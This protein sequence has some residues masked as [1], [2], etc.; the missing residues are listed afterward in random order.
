MKPS[1]KKLALLLE[2]IA[3]KELGVTDLIPQGVDRL[4]FVEIS[5]TSLK[6]ALKAAYEAGVREGASATRMLP[7]PKKLKGEI[8]KVRDYGTDTGWGF[9]GMLQKENLGNSTLEAITATAWKAIR[10]T[11]NVSPEEEPLIAELLVSRWGRH[12]ADTLVGH[13]GTED[14]LQERLRTELPGFRKAYEEIRE[15]ATAKN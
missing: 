2:D 8:A 12:L 10:R 15:Q 9:Y 6:A 3:R 13:L 4:D 11:F 14:E 1:A 5:K 7:L